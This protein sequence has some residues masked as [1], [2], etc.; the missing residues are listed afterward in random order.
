MGGILVKITSRGSH[1]GSALAAQLTLLENWL[2]IRGKIQT[3][4]KGNWYM[5]ISVSRLRVIAVIHD[6][7]QRP[8]VLFNSNTQF[9]ATLKILQRFWASGYVRLCWS[10]IVASRRPSASISRMSLAS[11]GLSTKHTIAATDSS[12]YARSVDTGGN[13]SRTPLSTVPRHG[14]SPVA[15]RSPH[16]YSQPTPTPLS[17]PPFSPVSTGIS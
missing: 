14:V 17:H 10:L 4:P 13:E 9:L 7:R 8:A 16:V 3:I 5:Y 12:R 6:H 15:P 11:V 1:R 2:L